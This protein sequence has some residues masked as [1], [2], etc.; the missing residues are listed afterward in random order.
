MNERLFPPFP[1]YRSAVTL[2]C[3]LVLT[4]GLALAAAAAEV[5]LERGGEIYA[6]RCAACHGDQG[7]GV[8]GNFP[9]P[10][11]G[12][13]SIVELAD[14]ITATMPEGEPEEC[15]GDDSLAVASYMY[16]AFYSE[17]AQQ[18]LIPPRAALARLTAEQHRQSVSDIFAHFMGRADLK[19]E[20]GL[21]ATYFD[22][23]GWR[24][25]KKVL[26]RTDPNVD[27]D[28]GQASPG[29][30]MEDEK[31]AV[32]WS[33]ALLPPETGTYLLRARGQGSFIVKFIDTGEKLFDNHVS[34]GEMAEHVTTVELVGGRLY[35]IS[36]DLIKRE[37]KTGNVDISLTLSWKPPRGIEEPIPTRYLV[38]GWAPTAFAPQA[39]M[40]PDD[41]SAGYV[42]GTTISRQWDD[43]TT[44]VALEFADALVS[45]VWPK[46]VKDQAKKKD[47][48]EGRD[49]LKKFCRELVEVAFRR[50]VDE[51]E[52]QRIVDDQFEATSDDDEVLR[53]VTLLT[54]KSPRFL[55]PT[56]DGDASVEHRR[57]GRL[58]LVLWDSIPDA[59]LRE[60]A[61]KGWLGDPKAV[62]ERARRM[63]DDP[64]ARAKTLK[65]LH[66]WLDLD[67][68]EEI[69]KNTE[70][71]PGFDEPLVADLR[72]SLDRFLEAVIWSETSDFRQ[73]L[74]AD[75]SYTTD[76]IAEFYGESWAPT[77]EDS[78]GRFSRTESDGA[79]RAG[80]VTHPLMMSA[81]AYEDA[82]A[83]I[84]R[85]VFLMR[86]LLGRMIRPPADAFSPLSPD[87]H[88]D[89]T[90]RQRVALQTSPASCQSCHTRIN[91]LGFTLEGFDAVGR[92]RQEERG[93]PI[94]ATGNYIDRLGQRIEFAG[95]ADLTSYLAVSDDVVAAFIKRLFLHFVKH[96]VGAYG[97][98]RLDELQT[99]FLES[100]YNVQELLV[101]MAVIA[102]D[103]PV[104][105]P[106]T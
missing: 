70:S 52:M 83:P 63:L 82:S 75:W 51:A 43:A 20:R 18:R 46:Y 31:F 72:G 39:P 64:R 23:P 33:G 66:E 79:V 49:L 58:A 56:L 101:E 44:A 69:S 105:P 15:V 21:T 81:L 24:N 92:L 55:Y 67:R 93:Q 27:V 54:L 48:P 1:V 100:G 65:G 84:F 19:S 98:N 80:V 10:L 85:G 5:D 29:E 90:T 68:W 2:A 4:V 13:S 62:R 26:T 36:V 74:Q 95:A 102:A 89:L 6:D 9:D 14:L 106:S 87:L 71:F 47:A 77:G 104:P 11:I 41:R 76:R 59:S 28:Y 38:P 25:E 35:P 78:D 50:P 91:G 8:A 99:S 45:K 96:P 94:D 86:H 17:T 53:R 57:A 16:E 73:L 103:G 34:S 7:Q 88:P 40:P 97:E 32:Y 61:D 22:H 30:G 12:D 3:G 60:A 37:R 42:R